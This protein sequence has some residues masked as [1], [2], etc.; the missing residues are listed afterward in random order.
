M[1]NRNEHHNGNVN[2]VLGRRRVRRGGEGEMIVF[3]ENF[4][5]CRELEH[6]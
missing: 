5:E 3:W 2:R 6:P 4:L 1:N